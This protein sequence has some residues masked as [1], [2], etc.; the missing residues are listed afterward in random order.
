MNI[1]ELYVLNRAIDGRDIFSLPALSELKI[2]DFLVESIKDG[3][4]KKGILE[5]YETF[6]KEGATITN[7]LRL[8]KEA[9]K[10]VIINDV[11][12]GIINEDE[13]VV[14]LYN[15]LV[16]DYKIMMIDTSEAT[17]QIVESCGFFSNMDRTNKINGDKK[18]VLLRKDF[19]KKYHL[20][21]DNSLRLIV[22]SQ[23]TAV[24]EV[25]FCADGKLY[26]YDYNESVLYEKTHE[27]I[28]SQ[29]SGRM[30]VS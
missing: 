30:R 13:S 4:I 28:I 1:N 20:K 14:F 16:D 27:G 8:F 19:S 15:S 5:S 12:L 6:T 23:G 11:S 22:K 25:Y 9:K 10:Y 24:D 29:L 3:L 2:S 21:S 18:I 26:V 17:M 7:R